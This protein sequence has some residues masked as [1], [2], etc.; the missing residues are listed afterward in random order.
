MKIQGVVS[1]LIFLL[2]AIFPLRS[3]GVPLGDLC[4]LS[5][6]G[7]ICAGTDDASRCQCLNEKALYCHEQCDGPAPSFLPCPEQPPTVIVAPRAAPLET[8]PTSI[9]ASTPKTSSS[10]VSATVS[11]K[12]ECGSR[13]LPSCPAGQICVKMPG[14]ACGPQTDCGGMCVP[15]NNANVVFASPSRSGASASSSST[16]PTEES[17]LVV[18]TPSSTATATGEEKTVQFKQN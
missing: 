1:L 17:V 4:K 14:A 3:G 18:A 10:T 12:F 9:P 15:R 6:E 16:T 13:G 8:S 2:G 11:R 7:S 5:C